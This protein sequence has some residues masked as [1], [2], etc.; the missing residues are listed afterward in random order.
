MRRLRDRPFVLVCSGLIAIAL[1]AGGILWAKADSQTK[2]VDLGAGLV[3]AG[4]FGVLLVLFE[5]ALSQQASD[6]ERTVKLGAAPEPPIDNPPPGRGIARSG[7]DETPSLGRPTSASRVFTVEREGWI[8]DSSRIDADQVRLRVFTNGEYFQFFVGVVAGTDFRPAIHGP[9]NITFAQFRRAFTDA[10][11]EHI[12]RVIRTG[13]APRPDPTQAI[14]VFPDAR[15]A[16]Q[17]ARYIEDRD[18]EEGQ[19]VAQWEE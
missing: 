11:V 14:E 16:A 12:R 1:V 15:E 17:R 9:A 7:V 4:V 18:Y 2:G 13:D 19:V 3:S 5:R 8:R 6:I 10:T